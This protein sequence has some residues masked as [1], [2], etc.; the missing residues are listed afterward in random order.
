MRPP[1]PGQAL[2][3]PTETAPASGS[4]SVPLVAPDLEPGDTLT[5]PPATS[6]S[7]R[8]AAPG[9]APIAD[10]KLPMLPWRVL[11]ILGLVTVFSSVGWQ[12]W[13]VFIGVERSPWLSVLTVVGAVAAVI[14]ILGWTWCVVENARRLLAPAMTQAPLSPTTITL[15]WLA[16]GIVAL[17]SVIAVTYLQRRLVLP[18]NDTNSAL[19]LVV[20]AAAGLATLVVALQ[21]LGMISDALRR[22]G[23]AALPTDRLI[24][25]PVALTVIGALSLAAMRAGG[26]FGEGFDGIA[27]AWAIGVV[28]ILPAVV[29]VSAMWRGAASAEDTVHLAFDRRNGITRTGVRHR[30]SLA[31]RLLRAEAFPRLPRADTKP[32][33]LVPGADATR[34]AM[35]IVLA[36]LCLVAIVGAVVMILFW[37][38]STSGTLARAQQQRAWDVLANLQ[39]LQRWL[40][41]G[42]LAITTIWAFITVLNA[43]LAT[44]RRQNPLIAAASWPLAAAAIWAIGG[45]IDGAEPHVVVAGFAAQAVVFG[46]PFLLLERAAVA[47]HAHRSPLRLTYILGV[48][49]LVQNQGLFGLSTL[50]LQS[51]LGDFGRLASSLAISALLQLAASLS[52]TESARLITDAAADLA[53]DHNAL[54]ERGRAAAARPSARPAL[55]PA[56]LGGA[57]VAPALVEDPVSTPPTPRVA[58]GRPDAG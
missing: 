48:V 53:D 9:L 17:G 4:A 39:I 49:L 42:L 34:L 13:R 50:E 56:Q 57:G 29:L 20:A 2:P 11:G 41:I 52:V 15:G 55:D 46:L 45:W 30:R 21:P 25:V 27:P 22:L 10:A 19:P 7:G 5:E 24:T 35:F 51:E 3:S 54:V 33:K 18:E 47:V 31:S 12:L 43:R 6:S 8:S 44:G 32:I 38:E 28:L 23:G 26:L 36:A 58:D 1:A 40:A 16:P 14:A 37:R